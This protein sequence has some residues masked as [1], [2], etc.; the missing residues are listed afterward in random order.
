MT[1]FGINNIGEEA[2]RSIQP[3]GMLLLLFLS[4]VLKRV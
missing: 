3:T 4:S 2:F 1:A